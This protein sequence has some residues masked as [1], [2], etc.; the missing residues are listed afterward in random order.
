M[1]NTVRVA[2]H[3]RRIAFVNR[4]LVLAAAL[5]GVVAFAN[6]GYSQDGLVTGVVL[7]GSGGQ[8]VANALVQVLDRRIQATT[9][10]AGRFA[11]GE[12]PIGEHI[13]RVSRI[14]FQIN[15]TVLVVSDTATVDL[16][17]T[18]DQVVFRL[19]DIIVTP[20]RFGVMEAPVV[21]QQ[22]MTREDLETV[23]QL[24]E[25]LFRAVK[26]LPGV[27]AG[28]ISTR[29]HVRGGT[30]QELLFQFDGLEL[31]EPYH[32]K[33]FDAV[34]GIVDVN[35]IGGIDLATGG[36]SVEHGDKLAGV[37]DMRSRTPPPSGTRTTLAL[38]IMNASIM[39][40][41][42]F[43]G[44]NGQ[45]LMSARRGY[46]DIAL[47][48]TGGN[49]ALSPIYGDLFGKLQYQVHRNHRLSVNFL[50]AFDD[51]NFRD[52]D[53]DGNLES[54]WSSSYGW[55]T[56]N[57]TPFS[58]VSTR[59]M[60]FAGR[61]NRR[62]GGWFDEL[63]R[64]RGPERATVSD[65]REFKFGGVKHDATIDVSD[66]LM[67]K[68][69]G[70]AKQLEADY[71]YTAALRTVTMT[72]AG[73]A[74]VFDT[75]DVDVEPSGQELSGYLSARFRPID[76]F[77]A[78]VGLRYDRIT[79]SDDDNVAP[80]AQAS[81]DVAPQTILRAS[82]GRYYQSHGIHELDVG[83][84]EERFFP[85]ER[86][87]QIA[88]GVEHRFSNDVNARVELYRR[89]LPEQRV[90]YINADRELDA[91]LEVE[92]DRIRLDA[93]R[94]QA[95]G[96]E[97]MI[98]RDQGRNWAWSASYALAEAKDEVSGTWIPRTLDQRH[99]LTANLAYRPNNVWHL[100]WAFHY[101]SGWPIT[102]SRFAVDTLLDGT[103]LLR[104]TFG[105]INGERLPAYHRIDF[106]VTRNFSVG[107]GILQA[108]LDLFN[109]YN[110]T[111]LR[112]YFY[113]ARLRNGAL[114]VSRV[115]GE[116]LLPILPSLGFRYEF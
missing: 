59:T 100:S 86:A 64:I 1:N 62:R 111:N 84:G 69:G 18:L 114:A 34:L 45:W 2:R 109:A 33:D 25:D 57:A 32:L 31:Y 46:L 35:S 21:A 38:S 79:Y 52:F 98:Q 89:R 83:D 28:D 76:P 103:T 106:R 73:L 71:R 3:G 92:G 81:F 80:R 12:V 96:L 90:R 9:D 55:L 104:R 49:D 29:L 10:S 77:T 75:L 26:R 39:N 85:S 105:P 68:I 110:H 48:L 15:T 36:F 60:T 54:S 53:E 65:R 17:I 78:E 56:W 40:Q 67:F 63:G 5:F 4:R 72:T 6:P 74:A 115:N 66:R 14:G 108:Y 23:P 94:G 113:R 102:E 16:T 13:L 42:G 41:G 44:G 97:V 116:E 22:T 8:P 30:D 50:H 7:S 24:G 20:G 82:W 93:G 112:S 99:A 27:A 70:E 58:H 101:H 107:R 11:L 37:F 87:D 91:F 47:A 88:V 19:R 61:L 51:L 95:K 43:D